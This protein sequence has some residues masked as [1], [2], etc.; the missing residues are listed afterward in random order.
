ML[1]TNHNLKLPKQSGVALL[2]VILCMIIITTMIGAMLRHV[3]LANRQ[4]K[5]RMYQ[6]QATWLVESGVERAVFAIQQDADYSQETW[7][8]TAEELDGQYAG[9]VEIRVHSET[10]DDSLVAVDVLAIYPHPSE[11]GVKVRKRIMVAKNN[12]FTLSQ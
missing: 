8:V 6:I 2:L 3:T 9:Q 4:M 7:R 11:F 5:Q 12:N 1:P 10:D